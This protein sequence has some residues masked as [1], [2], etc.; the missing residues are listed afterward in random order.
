MFQS[1]MIKSSI[2]QSSMP[3]FSKNLLRLFGSL[4]LV[5]LLNSFQAGAQGNERALADQYMNSGDFEKAAVLYDK[6]IDRDPYGVYPN[7]LRCLLSM[8]D[9]D[10]AEK[11]VKRQQK[12]QEGNL[13]LYVDLGQVYELQNQN[14]QYVLVKK[15]FYDLI[16]E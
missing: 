12:K 1:S 15:N 8:Q 4:L 14:D 3:Q 9:F 11:L 10:K 2:I 16:N 13:A 7:Y 5:C 6:L